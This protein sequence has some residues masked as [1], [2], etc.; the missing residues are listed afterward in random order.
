MANNPIEK[1][2]THYSFTNPASVF[3]EEAMTALE[4]AGRQGA[5]INEVV[6]DQ[7]GLRSETTERLAA[8][9]EYNEVTRTKYMPNFVND[10]VRSYI[11]TGQFDDAIDEYAG[12]LKERITNLE[13][14]YE[15]GGTTADAE[16]SDIRVG[17][18]GHIFET[19]GDAVREQANRFV[20]AITYENNKGKYVSAAQ[21]TIL[22]HELFKMSDA[23]Y[24]PPCVSK[25]HITTR[26]SNSYCA[27]YVFCTSDV[28]EGISLHTVGPG[29]EEG[30][31]EIEVPTEAR[32][33]F[34]LGDIMENG[35]DYGDPTVYLDKDEYSNAFE[36]MISDSERY[37][38]YL[39]N[40]FEPF[41]V[42]FKDNVWFYLSQSKTWESNTL[43]SV[44]DAIPVNEGEMIHIKVKTLNPYCCRA[45]FMKTNSHI[46]SDITY[47][48]N[49][50]KL[51]DYFIVAPAGTKYLFLQ[52]ETS[53]AGT[54]TGIPEAGREIYSA[55]QTVIDLAVSQVNS[56]SRAIELN[57][58]DVFP[59]V[60]G[61]TFQ[62]FWKGV[63]MVADPY[64]YHVKVECDIGKNYER[65]F[66]VTPLV[67]VVGEH[68]FT[69]TVYDDSGFEVGSKTI[70]LSVKNKADSPT[71]TKNVL[72]VGDSLTAAGVYPAEVY[73][74][75][76]SS[77]LTESPVGNGLKNINFIGSRST[78]GV[79]HEGLS[80]WTFNQFN[81]NTSPFYDSSAGVINFATYAS[82][83]GASSIDVMT[84]LL[85]WNST[86]TDI[87]NYRAEVETFI[88]NVKTSYPDCKII[89]FAPP[90]PSKDGLGESYGTSWTY[91][92]K[93]AKVKEFD[94]LYA[95]IASA[96][97]NVYYFNLSGVFDAE[98]GYPYEATPANY[99][100]TVK[101]NRQTNGVHPNESGYLQIADGV[102][103]ALTHVLKEV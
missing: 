3:D 84:V 89:L 61:D 23:I 52:S 42:N 62:L 59:L 83:V 38:T 5:K 28:L 51:G 49:P 85:G 10:S 70:T 24:I 65:F 86:M 41:E 15:P 68:L 81:S 2:R 80:G 93:V 55:N 63:L 32:Y 17:A 98:Y 21:K 6:D 20:F 71:A 76:T 27:K 103:R 82:N 91:H 36:Q 69:V 48:F 45:F 31:H 99:R 102:Y 35:S 39:K 19:A 87:S 56:A 33:L 53:T 37:V 79:K 96:Q 46:N 29:L 40:N 14:N 26:V 95:S 11:K 92:E 30:S 64:K 73:R 47:A 22:K 8:Q 57:L 100:S 16:L 67:G 94:E 9:D 101:I 13:T 90:F 18:D 44:S 12:L 60:V 7:N 1:L 25:I 72:V 78:N 50:K 75:L 77:L 34:V 58:P 4:L 74:R 66:E 54:T 88:T 43:F 97:D